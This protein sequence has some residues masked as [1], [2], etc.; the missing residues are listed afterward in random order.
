MI[1][2]KMYEIGGWVYEMRFLPLRLDIGDG[3]FAAGEDAFRAAQ[4]ER[5]VEDGIANLMA[6]EHLARL[7]IHAQ[8]ESVLGADPECAILLQRHSRVVLVAKVGVGH[9]AGGG[10]RWAIG[11]W[12]LAIGYWVWCSVDSDDGVPHTLGIDGLAVFAQAHRLAYLILVG[13]P[14]DSARFGIEASEIA[15]GS[16]DEDLAIGCHRPHAG[17]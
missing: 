14:N 15:V 12:Q 7:S 5:G 2:G 11:Y 4:R 10:G 6:E 3:A 13:A 17:R 1:A 8:E 16:G 9:P